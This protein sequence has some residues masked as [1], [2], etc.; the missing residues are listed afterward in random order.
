MHYHY[1]WFKTIDDV[2]LNHTAPIGDRIREMRRDAG[3]SQAKLALQLGIAR[4]TLVNY[5]IGKRPIPHTVLEQIGHDYKTDITW[6]VLG[7]AD[8]PT[9]DYYLYLFKAVAQAREEY[10]KFEKRNVGW[11]DASDGERTAI[12]ATGERIYEIGGENALSASYR[13]FFPADE[14]R[15]LAAGSHL[16][17]LW[18]GIGGWRA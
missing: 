18:S 2:R 7:I 3:V 10:V 5:E 9:T 14:N 8:R 16:N 11:T 17:H 12:R 15:T 6:L 13:A 1:P 4:N